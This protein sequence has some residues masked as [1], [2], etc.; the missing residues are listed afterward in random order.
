MAEIGSAA[1]PGGRNRPPVG[2][3]SL[4]RA[5][6]TGMTVP[7]GLGRFLE[8]RESRIAAGVPSAWPEDL[9]GETQWSRIASDVAAAAKLAEELDELEEMRHE[10]ASSRKAL[11][12]AEQ[13]RDEAVETR[14]TAT[15][16]AE[17]LALTEVNRGVL[18]TGR[19][20]SR[21]SA[22]I[23]RPS[24]RTRDGARGPTRSRR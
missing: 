17:A 9:R 20:S 24:A 14:F 1:S 3:W 16:V 21:G 19:S 18:S 2:A 15:S 6:L 7:G 11:R 12:R 23:V 5:P 10:L 22:S 8:L 13:E 4:T